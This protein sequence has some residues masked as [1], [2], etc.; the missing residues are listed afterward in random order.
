MFDYQKIYE[1]TKKL[2]ILLVED[3]EPLRKELKEILEDF[4]ADV[5]TAT[6]GQEALGCYQERLSQNRPY[7]MVMSDIQMP[8]MDGV[9]LS[10]KIKELN[11]EQSIV[12]LSAYA[13]KDYLLELINI[14]IAKFIT[15]PIDYDSFFSMLYHEGSRLSSEP[16]NTQRSDVI[17]FDQHYS[18]DKQARVLR[19]DDE[20]VTLTKHELLLLEFFVSKLEHL[21]TSEEIIEMFYSHYIDMSEKNIRNLVFKL[22]KKVPQGCIQSIY[23]LGY[24]FSCTHT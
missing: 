19:C 13:D 7:D 17:Y 12:I 6:N 16:D 18:W 8:K 15:K 2:S 22:R 1:K 14:Q 9:L 5:T 23:G 3:Y 21:C 10:K 24:K 20:V 4:F 11:K